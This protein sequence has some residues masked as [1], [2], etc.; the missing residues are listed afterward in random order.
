MRITWVDNLKAL[1]IFLVVFGHILPNQYISSF[2]IPLFFFISGYLFDRDKYDFPQFFRKK[3]FTLIIPYLF[4]AVASFLFWYFVVRNVGLGGKAL[5]IDPLKPIIGTLYGICFGD[6]RTPINVALWFL[7][8][9]FV[10][11]TSFYFV[12]SRWALI[13][14][15]VLGYLVVLL[16]FRL[17][18]GSDIS[19]AAIVFYGAGY[20]YRKDVINLPLIAMPF[21]FIL[22]AGFC[23]LNGTV[24]M[25]GLEYGNPVY[26]Y[27]SAFSGILLCS[28]L[29]RHLK[30]SRV[31]EYIGS[32]T[33]ILVGM[34]GFAWYAVNGGWYIA[35]HH[36]IEQ[37]G[38]AFSFAL[39]VLQI[40]L[41]IPAIYVINRWL[42][43]V[44]GK[45]TGLKSQ[46]QPRERIP[47]RFQSSCCPWFLYIQK[48]PCP[49]LHLAV[50][51]FRQY[52]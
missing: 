12:K 36:K 43:F 26:F 48:P 4:F 33:I 10:T 18:W 5:A 32:N 11:E 29:C 20:F 14:F 52:P 13:A 47:P 42:P 16:P 15:A 31:L 34:M 8:C 38:L 1:G 30:K 17:P 19:M 28:E 9:L 49:M 24:D 25:N 23:Y 6:Y 45:P 51:C 39:A 46:L 37:P 2:H 27:I 41:T 35:F 22:S 50:W 44:L 21:L 40:G 3:F 7:P